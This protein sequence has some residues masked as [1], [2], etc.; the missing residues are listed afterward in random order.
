MK[1]LIYI[2]N[3]RQEEAELDIDHVKDNLERAAKIPEEIIN[4]MTIISSFAHKDREEMY[5]MIFSGEY[6]ICTWSMYTATHYNSIGQFLR[7]MNQA[8]ICEIKDIVYIDG[9]G[10]LMKDLNR[11]LD[12]DCK[13]AINVLQA[14]ETNYII[15][16]ENNEVF[17]L[18]LGMK[19]KYQNMFKKEKVDLLKLI[20][21][22]NTTI[23]RKT[24]RERKK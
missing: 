12:N 2:D 13:N 19:G 5:E 20:Q 22:E 7:F 17:R 23:P 10:N 3:D 11:V 8:A 6:V 15:S 16:F 4:S 24:R 1:K 9:S 18:R 21:G 14:L